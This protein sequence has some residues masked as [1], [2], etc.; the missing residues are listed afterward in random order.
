MAE[1]LIISISGVRGVIGENLSA[2]IAADFSAAFGTFLKN[3]IQE[4]KSQNNIPK[5]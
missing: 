4:I 2:S 5:M 3:K 1:N